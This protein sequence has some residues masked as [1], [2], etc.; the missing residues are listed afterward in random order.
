MFESLRRGVVKV[1]VFA[2]FSVLILSFAVWGIGDMITSRG[3]GPIAEVGKTKIPATQFT[4][5]LQQRRQIISQQFGQ[6]LTAEQSRAFGID[7]AVLGELV[8]AA[9]I[10]NYGEQLGLRLSDQTIAEL[11]RSDPVFFGPNQVFDRRTFDERIRQAGYTEQRYFAERRRDELREQI[12]EA[13]VEPVTVPDAMLSTL[14]K[15]REE[16]RTISFVRLDPSKLPPV[17][18]PD[19][20]ALKAF[21]EEQKT[22]F[23][24]PERRRL[25]IML[26]EPETLK[27]RLGVTDADVRASWE[28]SRPAWDVP[29]RRRIQQ[30]SY[31]TKEEAE[32]EAKAIAAGKSFLIAAL[33]ANGAQGRVDQGL[34]ARREISDPN[35]AKTAFELQPN[36]VSAPI[37]VRGG[38]LVIRVTE[39]QPARTRTFEEVAPEV[40]R[41]LEETRLRDK[42]TKLHED[43]EDRRGATAETEKYKKIAADLGLRVIEVPSVDARGL[44]PDGKPAIPHSAA[45]RI[46]ATAFQGEKDLPRE[47]LALDDGIEAW[48]EVV[49]VLPAATRPFDEVKADVE[50]RW[51]ER[52]ARQAL[53]R[54]SQ[55]LVDRIKAG[56][57][58][59]KIATETG[60]KIEVSKPFKRTAP[61]EGVAQGGARL[62]FTLPKGGAGSAMS[63]DDQTRI[64][65][66]VTDI[67]DAPPPTKEQTDAL[68]AQLVQDLQR[69]VIQSFVT[70]LRDEQGVRIDDAVYR[71][72]VG[73]DQTP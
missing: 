69:D 70:A 58:L 25:A 26:L 20:A 64:V 49:D 71:R 21:Y 57:P 7:Q 46:L 34:I 33:E 6:P 5:V 41:N 29:E 22:A 66:V 23:T 68:R 11:I 37:Q 2:L 56:E 40:R 31:R 72:A 8:S 32:G 50:Q 14:H 54:E 12:T 60:G 43:I 51:R 48:V 39:I 16:T 36:T 10:S 42:I 62:A 13:M 18:A 59:D 27:T 17:A 53:T 30:I 1:M 63:A 67:A 38:Y 55:K 44:G 19:E 52:E 73:L 3:Q 4:Q 61:P 28:Q 9:A 15:Y 24:I 45:D 35:F 65:M 47:V